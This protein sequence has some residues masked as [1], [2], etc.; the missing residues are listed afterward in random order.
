MSNLINLINFII[1]FTK[2]DLKTRYAGSLLGISWVFFQSIFLIGIYYFI[3]SVIFKIKLGPIAGT[4]SFFIFLIIA[5]FPWIG[6]QEG[7][8]RSSTIIFEN[9]EAVKKIPFPLEAL[10]ISVNLS[11]TIIHFS[12]FLLFIILYGIY[13]YTKSG[14]FLPL[15]II[16]IPFILFFQILMGIGISLILASFTTYIKDITQIFSILFQ[17][18][19]YATPIVYPIYMIPEN[20]QFIIKI[21]PFTGF[22]EIYRDIILTGKFDFQY[23]LLWS[24]LFSLII[25]AIGMKVFKKLKT[26]FVDV[27]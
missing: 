17:V 15:T 21:N 4:E 27:I 6:F 13:T 10:P 2:K 25:F 9:S 7:C 14:I 20:F 5:L 1:F 19:F 12:G 11:A 24:F 22:V 3:F 26:G 8:M 18:W 23:S 16:Y